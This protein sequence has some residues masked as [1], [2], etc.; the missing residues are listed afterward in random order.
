MTFCKIAHVYKI[1]NAGTVGRRI[2][3]T[4]QCEGWPKAQRCIDRERHEM[5]LG[6]MGLAYLI[7]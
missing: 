4:Q 3:V 1:A 2:V 5:C 6:I 7:F